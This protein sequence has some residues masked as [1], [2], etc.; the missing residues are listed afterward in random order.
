MILK[1]SRFVGVY[2]FLSNVNKSSA[3]VLITTSILCDCGKQ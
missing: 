2:R 3:N 1:N